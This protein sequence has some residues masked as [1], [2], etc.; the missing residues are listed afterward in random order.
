[1]KELYEEKVSPVSEVREHNKTEERVIQ[2]M[3]DQKTQWD[4]D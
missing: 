3:N 4:N 1:M 2:N